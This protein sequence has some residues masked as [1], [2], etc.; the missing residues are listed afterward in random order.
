MALTD[1]ARGPRAAWLR[2]NRRERFGSGEGGLAKLSDALRQQGLDRSPTTIKGWESSD[3]RSPIPPDV[4]PV[5]ERL[6]GEPAP[7]PTSTSTTPELVSALHAQTQALTDLVQEIRGGRGLMV[8]EAK[9]TYDDVDEATRRRRRAYWIARALEE[10]KPPL[11]AATIAKRMNWSSSQLGP[12]RAWLRGEIP[13]GATRAAFAQAVMLPLQV[14]EEPPPTD[15]E[16]LVEWRRESVGEVP[17][18]EREERPA[19]QRRSA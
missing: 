12:V 13:D 2:R 16:R 11:N 9:A 5:L 17:A 15:H 6:F 18:L 1:A 8:G 3:D 14:L 4:L 19:R 10:E 7:R